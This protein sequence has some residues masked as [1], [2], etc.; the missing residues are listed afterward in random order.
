MIEDVVL[1]APVLAS[2]LREGSSLPPHGNALGLLLG[3]ILPQ[4]TSAVTSARSN[5]IPRKLAI[6]VSFLEL[7]T[8]TFSPYGRLDTN[9]LN[10]FL[11][12]HKRTSSEVIG[13]YS[14]RPNTPLIPSIKEHTWLK[15]LHACLASGSLPLLL[16]SSVAI[17][18]ALAS[19]AARAQTRAGASV[20]HF[21]LEGGR[22]RPVQ[23][24]VPSLPST[25]GDYTGLVETGGGK[26]TEAERKVFEDGMAATGALV[27]ERLDRVS[28]LVKELKEL[29]ERNGAK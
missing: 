17:P 1:P 3:R 14:I 22:L 29:E 2:L 10:S 18:S 27:D 16:L 4:T 15:R 6:V 21:V 23:T 11:A 24:K 12:E 9:V 5:N 26:A 13:I 7:D 19:S 25:V 8:Q 20:R 28:M